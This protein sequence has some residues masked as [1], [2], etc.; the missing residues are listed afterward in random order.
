MGASPEGTVVGKDARV[1]APSAACPHQVDRSLV[2]G[3][4]S[5]DQQGTD[6]QSFVDVAEGLRLLRAAPTLGKGRGALGR[7]RRKEVTSQ[8]G[9]RRSTAD[10]SDYHALVAGALIEAAASEI[11]VRQ[12]G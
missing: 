4:S 7:R 8:A 11:V 9:R 12:R 10:L 1:S 5:A 6:K 3:P 2:G